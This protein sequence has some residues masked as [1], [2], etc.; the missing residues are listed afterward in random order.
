MFRRYAAQ[1]Q[2]FVSGSED[3]T[4]EFGVKLGQT[5]NKG[6]V[7]SLTGNLGAGK[8][9]LCAGVCSALGVKETVTSPTYTIIHEYE[10]IFPVYHIDVY[11]LS[12]TD[13]FENSVGGEL[14][15]GEG[16]CLIEWGERIGECLPPE[17]IHIEIKILGGGNREIHVRGIT[18]LQAQT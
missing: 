13:D 14:L 1:N 8:T 11:R 5:L 12:G 3:E 15:R 4:F 10:G 2:I 18:D 7:I 9:R 6:G 17:T 16:V